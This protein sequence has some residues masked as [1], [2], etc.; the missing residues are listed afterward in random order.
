MNIKFGGVCYTNVPKPRPVVPYLTMILVA[1]IVAAGIMFAFVPKQYPA[2]LIAVSLGVIA[3]TK[4]MYITNITQSTRAEC[5]DGKVFCVDEK[6]RLDSI[7]VE[8]W[9][10][11]QTPNTLRCT[12]QRMYDECM[13]KVLT[14]EDYGDSLTVAFDIKI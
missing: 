10:C 11:T 7:P 1:I 3:L 9:P 2:I 13:A 5:T 8:P 14:F 12:A 4:Y 6:K